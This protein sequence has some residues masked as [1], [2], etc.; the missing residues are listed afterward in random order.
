MSISAF[1]LAD[2]SFPLPLSLLNYRLVII[3][4]KCLKQVMSRMDHN[5]LSWL[6]ESL[7]SLFEYI[8][9]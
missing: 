6:C 9:L 2:G 5:L 3:G 7:D 1:I 4:S 8:K